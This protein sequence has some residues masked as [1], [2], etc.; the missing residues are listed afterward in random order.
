MTLKGLFAWRKPLKRI[1]ITLFV[2]FIIKT[3]WLTA[4]QVS[5]EDVFSHNAKNDWM[6]RRAYLLQR[7]IEN[8]ITPKDMPAFLPPL[9]KGEWAFGTYAMTAYAVTNLAFHFP[10]TQPEAIGIVHQLIT[11][12]LT[13][14]IRQFDTRQ[15]RG[16]DA[17]A[18]LG[19][20]NGHIAYLG[21]LNMMLAAYHYLGGTDPKLTQLFQQNSDH[22]FQSINRVPFLNAET[23]PREIYTMDNAVAIASLTLHDQLWPS[24]AKGLSARWL[25]FMTHNYQ[26]K[27]TG[28]FPFSF[29]RDGR[30]YQ[31]SRGS[32]AGW[33]SFYLFYGDSHF[34]KDKFNK[35]VRHLVAEPF[36]GITGVNEWPS[37]EGHGDVDSGPLILGLSPSGTGFS[38]AGAV[39]TENNALLDDFLFTA[40]LAGFSWQWNGQ[41]R[42]LFAPLVGD[43]IVL[44]MVTT[45]PWDSRYL[46]QN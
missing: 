1:S 29:G 10:E 8:P 33:N 9:F 41:R 24:R 30:A 38:I 21:Q 7:T 27:T 6:T 13:P 22:L 26:D 18:D 15:W 32:A 25:N 31:Y 42:Y 19:S 39:F 4:F 43:A 23:Y 11:Q 34:A 17:L 28:L 20:E 36:P 40:E 16:K 46:Q 3:I 37:G 5:A 2:L 35:L 45:T 14:E 12:L 44:A